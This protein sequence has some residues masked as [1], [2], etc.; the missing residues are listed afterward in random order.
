VIEVD[1]INHFLIY[2]LSGKIA[3]G[4]NFETYFL[5]GEKNGNLSVFSI[6]KAKK[7]DNQTKIDFLK[8]LF[9]PKT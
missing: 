2:K 4:N 3:E 5:A 1:E 6:N 8:D 7:W 9:L